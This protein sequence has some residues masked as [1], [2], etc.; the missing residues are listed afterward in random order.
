MVSKMAFA[1][2]NRKEGRESRGSMY[3]CII[4]N[5]Y[6]KQA[7]VTAVGVG[8]WCVSAKRLIEVT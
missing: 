4:Y 8:V 3:S 1:K 2:K 5:D 6:T 7:I